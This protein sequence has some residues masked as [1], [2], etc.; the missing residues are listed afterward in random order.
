LRNFGKHPLGSPRK[1]WEDNI[2]MDSREMDYD[3]GWWMELVQDC[4]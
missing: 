1:K 4:G 2:N 3:D